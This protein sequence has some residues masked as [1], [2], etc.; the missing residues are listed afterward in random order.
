MED[1]KEILSD[2]EFYPYFDE[3]KYLN[4]KQ[5][6]CNF[7]HFSKEVFAVFWHLELSDIHVPKDLYDERIK[8]KEK[9]L[10]EC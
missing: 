5:K 10:K 4:K 1:G 2:P 6:K 9:E 3:T 8:M 7:N